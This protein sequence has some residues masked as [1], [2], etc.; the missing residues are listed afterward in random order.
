MVC[1][2]SVALLQVRQLAVGLP[3]LG[4][5]SI[6]RG[7]SPPAASAGAPVGALSIKARNTMPY[8]GLLLQCLHKVVTRQSQGRHLCRIRCEHGQAL[9]GL[10]HSAPAALL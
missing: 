10:A 4:Y 8:N 2:R 3:L 6:W 1:P 7:C 5:W 9:Q